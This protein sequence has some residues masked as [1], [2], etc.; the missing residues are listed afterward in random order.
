MIRAALCSSYCL[1]TIN[2]YTI[3]LKW[4]LASFL[5]VSMSSCNFGPKPDKVIKM[6]L[7]FDNNKQSDDEVN[8]V[9]EVLKKRISKIS[10]DFNVE[11]LVNSNQITINIETHYDPERIKNLVINQGRL[12]FYET[13]QMEEMMS[14]MIDV[15]D[16][17][18]KGEGSENPLFDLVK[19][20]GYQ[21]GP[22][23]INVSEKDTASVNAYLSLKG[24]ES[25]LPAQRRFVKF[26]WG[27]KEKGTKELPLY[28]LK[29]NKQIKP[30]LTGEVVNQARQ[31]FDQMARPT[32]TMAMNEEGAKV[33]EDLTGKAFQER[34][35]IAIVFNDLVYSAPGVA[36]GPIV[37]GNSQ[38]TG[39]FTVEEAQDFAAIL[40]SGSIPKMTIVDMVVE[41]LK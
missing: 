28:A 21:G 26:L 34:F 30:A 25:S 38:I 27:R 37:G 22:V 35:Q 29:L 7:E 36:S 2:M 6:T 8:A 33:W 4:V 17:L 16:M 10:R 23:L 32:V 12:D 15:N 14:F 24:A 11:K 19:R 18:K 31:E 9:V 13:Y 20:Q 3:F 40:E 1:N 5:S 39:D 41:K